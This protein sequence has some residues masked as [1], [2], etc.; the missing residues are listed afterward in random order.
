PGAEAGEFTAAAKVTSISEWQEAM[1][2]LGDLAAGQGRPLNAATYYRAAEFFLP[3]DD[4]R[5]LAAY[6]R[7]REE[8]AA[9]DVGWPYE[10]VE[11]AYGDGALPAYRF[12]PSG[13]ARDRVLIHGGFDSYAEEF[14]FWAAEWAQAGFEVIVFEGPGQGGALRDFGLTMD[15]FWEA[16]VGAMLDHFR[17]EDCT[18]I[19]LSLGGCLAPR[20]AAFEAR[21]Q[22]V[23]ALDVLYDFFDCF[24]ARLGPAVATAISR[25][26]A[27]GDD[28]AVQALFERVTQAQPSLA[29]AA[30]HGRHISGS[31]SVAEYL[32]WLK[33]MSTGS[34]SGLIRQDVLVMAGTEDHIVPL[35]QFYKQVAALTNVRS[36][37]AR[38]FTEAE[39]GQAHCRVGAMR[40][41]LDY[42]RDWIEFHLARAAPAARAA[43]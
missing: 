33:A 22:R 1:L 20:A 36:L 15:P 29:W 42:M 40:L 28:A 34:F 35:D 3:F 7:Y 32:R 2:R 27:C 38:L 14:L 12:T 37:T 6:R 39:D 8:I 13:A 30:A 43:A 25:R 18:L 9:V 11:A 19:G 41:V 4:P 24:G 5:K 17:I 31:Q 26:L 10:R 16:P 21:I 23:I